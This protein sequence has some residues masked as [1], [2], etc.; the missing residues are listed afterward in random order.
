MNRQGGAV[1]VLVLVVLFGVSIVSLTA[2]RSSVVAGQSS[3]HAIG[4]TVA[5]SAARAA[6]SDAELEIAAGSRS[7]VFSDPA[8]WPPAGCGKDASTGICALETNTA[9]RRVD[10]ADGGEPVV[11]GAFTGVAVPVGAHSLPARL[12]RYLV[13]VMP[14]Q[15]AGE[16]ASVPRD[17]VFRI[18]A[19]GYGPDPRTVAVIQST[20]RL[21]RP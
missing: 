2:A 20:F 11:M 21:A 1:L 18:T 17:P 8:L 14:D 19:I 15:E 13:E 9:W 3:R 10:L 12:P 7:A 16:D 6:L 5:H 4:H